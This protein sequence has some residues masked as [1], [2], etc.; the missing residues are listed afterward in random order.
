LPSSSRDAGNRISFARLRGFARTHDSDLC[1]DSTESRVQ[2]VL[3]GAVSLILDRAPQ[4]GR[5]SDPLVAPRLAAP[6]PARQ[7]DQRSTEIERN[8]PG[9]GD[10]PAKAERGI[11]SEPTVRFLADN[12]R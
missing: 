10:A 9:G 4:V 2:S 1:P 7:A 8:P 5:I 11:N 6:A 12:S 3:L